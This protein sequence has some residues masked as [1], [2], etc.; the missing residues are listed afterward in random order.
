MLS[1]KYGTFFTLNRIYCPVVTLK[2]DIDMCDWM[3]PIMDLDD[4]LF[5]EDAGGPSER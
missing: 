2:G 4:W 5:D 1:R 3:D